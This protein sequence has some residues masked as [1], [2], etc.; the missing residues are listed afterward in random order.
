MDYLSV[1]LLFLRL[2][3]IFCLRGQDEALQ[4]FLLLMH[5]ATR[6]I[7][8]EWDTLMLLLLLTY[9]DVNTTGRDTLLEV[10]G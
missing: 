6:P 9:R 1:M 7:S 2:S 5:S 8:D 4:I 3:Q 10:S